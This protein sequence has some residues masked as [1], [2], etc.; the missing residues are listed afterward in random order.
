MVGMLR[1]ELG[2]GKD[3]MLLQLLVLVV[4][5]V[6][7]LL[8]APARI[9][10]HELKILWVVRIASPLPPQ[11]L[12]LELNHE[13]QLVVHASYALSLLLRHG[14]HMTAVRLA[15]LLLLL[16]VVLVVVVVVVPSAT[17]TITATTITVAAAGAKTVAVALCVHVRRRI[18]PSGR[19]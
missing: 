5:L 4:L 12:L 14:R 17:A 15:L 1:S 11:L 3:V 6:V 2:K 19:S 9:L 10:Q 13:C 7:L 18:R 8:V 16:V